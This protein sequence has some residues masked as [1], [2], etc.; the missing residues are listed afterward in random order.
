MAGSFMAKLNAVRVF[1][2]RGIIDA[3]QFWL[4]LE[5]VYPCDS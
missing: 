5:C 3:S 2:R 1:G 4:I